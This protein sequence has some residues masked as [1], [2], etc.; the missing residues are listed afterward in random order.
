[1]AFGGGGGWGTAE[2][3]EGEAVS[4]EGDYTGYSDFSTR[5]AAPPGSAKSSMDLGGRDAPPLFHHPPPQQ[6]HTPPARFVPPPQQ[7]HPFLPLG[8][9]SGAVR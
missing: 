6:P 1:M 5:F 3:Q 9:W 8:W 2:R 4:T 7:P